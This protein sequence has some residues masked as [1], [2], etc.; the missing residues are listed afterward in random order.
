[1]TYYVGQSAWT[2]TSPG[3]YANLGTLRLSSI[4]G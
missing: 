1:M 2:K 4:R 3:S